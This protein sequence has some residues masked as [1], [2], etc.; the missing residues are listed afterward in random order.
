M[1]SGHNKWL[2]RSGGWARNMRSMSLAAARLAQALYKQENIPHTQGE[3]ASMNLQR[4]GDCI[5]VPIDN[6]EFPKRCIKTGTQLDSI[7]FPIAIDVIRQHAGN[8]SA[9]LAGAVL[10]GQTG[11]NAVKVA[12]GLK[13]KTR[14][15]CNIALSGQIQAKK[16]RLKRASIV[17]MLLV[18]VVFAVV[19]SL[20]AM[21]I[22]AIPND[23][24]D[25][26]ALIIGGV[27][28]ATIFL[29]VALFAVSDNT[30][31]REKRND[32]QRIWL[33]GACS[34]FLGGLPAFDPDT[35]SRD[36]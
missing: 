24:P 18:P 23:L 5:V 21:E 17:T 8:E 36:G 10:G 26:Y 25:I 19:A 32:G 6:P 11:R 12:A 29:G 16:R 9:E 35:P 34:E 7:D 2:N 33:I 15:S 22:F 31:L 27:A 14:F 30:V 13:N 28:V 1:K 4:D 20:V 3:N